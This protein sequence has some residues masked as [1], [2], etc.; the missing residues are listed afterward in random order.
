MT[1]WTPERIARLRLLWCGPATA[2]EIAHEL[3]VTR[4][5]VIGKARRLGVV[6]GSVTPKLPEVRP[7]V[8]PQPAITCSTDGC[9]FTPQPSDWQRRCSGCIRRAIALVQEPTTEKGAIIPRG[10]G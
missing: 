2:R 8:L 10:F 5:M 6:C 1:S 9:R 3:G 4:N 7:P